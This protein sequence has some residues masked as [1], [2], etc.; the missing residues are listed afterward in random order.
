M[1]KIIEG[2]NIRFNTLIQAKKV[3]CNICNKISE[4]TKC[5]AEVSAEGMDL[6]IKI[7]D[8]GIEIKINT[9]MLVRK[10]DSEME[11]KIITEIYKKIN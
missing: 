4:D 3:A 6:I 8:L 2:I 5:K 10:S 11:S 9:R 1:E 7:E